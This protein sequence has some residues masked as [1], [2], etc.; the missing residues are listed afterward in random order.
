MNDYLDFD[1]TEGVYENKPKENKWL[2]PSTNETVYFVPFQPVKEDYA[3][4]KTPYL[5]TFNAVTYNIKQEYKSL[6]KMFSSYL[7]LTDD[8]QD[9]ANW[10]L[11]MDSKT[12]KLPITWTLN[13]YIMM[14]VRT[15][16]IKHTTPLSPSE[17]TKL[18]FNKVGI[19]Q[20]KQG[21][22]AK[23]KMRYAYDWLTQLGMYPENSVSMWSKK[24]SKD[25][26]GNIIVSS[27]STS[28]ST[29]PK[30]PTSIELET[31]LEDEYNIRKDV[32]GVGLKD[33]VKKMTWLLDWCETNVVAVPEHIT[34]SY[35]Q[36]QAERAEAQ[37]LTK[38]DENI[39]F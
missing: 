22:T 25:D 33:Q 39:Q 2:T 9:L 8:K 30:Q 20:F 34:N 28:L 15:D 37:S 24:G 6:S 19:V 18:V 31:P 1:A 3:S 17:I 36:V 5:T 13:N 4:V 12:S 7:V 16:G 35:K 29:F 10:L 27:V 23:S 26:K 38:K 14:L 32:F 11:T 21:Y